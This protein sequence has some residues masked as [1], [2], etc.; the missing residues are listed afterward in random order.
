M[1]K[2]QI[3][4]EAE[5]E[6]DVAEVP[7]LPKQY[8]LGKGDYFVPYDANASDFEDVATLLENYTTSLGDEPRESD[9]QGNPTP[10][11]QDVTMWYDVEKNEVKVFKGHDSNGSCLWEVQPYARKFVVSLK[12]EDLSS[13]IGEIR[14][15]HKEAEA[16][17]SAAAE[18]K[19]NELRPESV[20]FSDL[21]NAH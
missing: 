18:E 9:D 5:A 11:V 10:H 8:K 13:L 19:L 7:T 1:A 14:N 3:I 16:K 21:L 12:E 6:L 20:S 15:S 4:D 2:K 17:Y